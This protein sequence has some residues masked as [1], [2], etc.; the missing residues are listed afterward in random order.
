MY[1]RARLTSRQRSAPNI[2]SNYVNEVAQTDVDFPVMTLR[3]A[4]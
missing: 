1:A 3:E 4:A 2:W